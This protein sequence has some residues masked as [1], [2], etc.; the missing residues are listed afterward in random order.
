M[1]SDVRELLHVADIFVFPTLTEGLPL[2]LLEAAAVGKPCVASDIPPDR[3]TIQNGNTGLL[4]KSGGPKKLNELI[5]YLVRNEDRKKH[6]GTAA[7]QFV[8]KKFNHSH[9]VHLLEELYLRTY[10]QVIQKL[11]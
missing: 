10:R 4:V 3:E 11:Q 2:T 8:E 9:L 5:L 7:K 1:R 6:F